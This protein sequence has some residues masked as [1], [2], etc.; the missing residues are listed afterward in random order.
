MT[1]KIDAW[2]A[3]ATFLIAVPA[4]W[5]GVRVARHDLQSKQAEREAANRAEL[6]VRLERSPDQFVI[7][8][9]GGAAAS[10]VTFDLTSALTSKD[11]MA[12]DRRKL[13]LSRLDAGQECAFGAVIL[14]EADTKFGVVLTWRDPDDKVQRRDTEVYV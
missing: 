3:L 9:V 10:Q 14:W 13:P 7:F 8:N 4:A 5:Y 11:R 1:D 2:I 12:H 6:R